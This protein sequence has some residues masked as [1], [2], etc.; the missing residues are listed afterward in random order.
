M[1]Q[2]KAFTSDT[3]IFFTWE[4]TTS[5]SRML[6]LQIA[7]LYGYYQNWRNAKKRLKEWIE[8]FLHF[9]LTLEHSTVENVTNSTQGM[10]PIAKIEIAI[11]IPIMIRN[12]DR[13]RDPDLNLKIICDPIAI[14]APAIADL[15]GDLL[16]NFMQECNGKKWRQNQNYTL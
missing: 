2:R 8:K 5:V 4:R 7:K 15:L 3:L 16:K 1:L 9:C 13:D 12:W 6:C 11:P 10:T 14:A